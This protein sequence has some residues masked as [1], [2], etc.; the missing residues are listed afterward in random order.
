ME[1]VFLRKWQWGVLLVVLTM[2]ALLGW[3][4]RDLLIDMLLGGSL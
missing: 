1:K 3:M 4:V 2:G